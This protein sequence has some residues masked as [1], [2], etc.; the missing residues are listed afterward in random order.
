MINPWDAFAQEKLKK[1]FTEK[2]TVI[3]IGG[4]LRVDGSKNNRLDP[5]NKWLEPYI[6][7]VDYKVLDKVAD[8]KPDIVGDI[9][10]LPFADNSIDAFICVAVLEHVEEPQQAVKEMYRA[11]KPGGYC[12]IYVPFL[13]YYHPME[14]Y[15]KDFYRFTRDGVKY[16]TR[17]FK[18]V[19]M[20]NV[21]G[22]LSTL[23]NLF[24]LFSK[25]TKMFDWLDA[26]IGKVKTKQTS[27]YIIFCV[28]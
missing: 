24:P 1:I 2:K 27:G 8:Y 17:D 11:L 21:R 26:L 9:H 14:G 12:Y 19:E 6:A 18:S 13:Y 20:Q 16:L 10:T 23:A 25:K 4:G 22:A 28:K 5:K 3:D 7:K 15:Y